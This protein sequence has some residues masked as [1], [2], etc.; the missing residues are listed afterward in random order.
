MGGGQLRGSCLVPPFEGCGVTFTVTASEFLAVTLT[1]TGR[2]LELFRFVLIE[3][4]ND[5]CGASTCWAD[6]WSRARFISSSI[7][8]RSMSLSMGESLGWDG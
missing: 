1:W 3:G 8:V 4:G 2:A 6:S 5:T 7:R